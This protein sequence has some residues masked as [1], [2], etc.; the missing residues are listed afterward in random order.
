[1][2]SHFHTGGRAASSIGTTAIETI[3]SPAASNFRGDWDEQSLTASQAAAA[4]AS[5][6]TSTPYY[7]CMTMTEKQ[8]LLSTNSEA[9]KAYYSKLLMVVRAL[10]WV[11]FDLLG[12]DAFATEIAAAKPSGL[13]FVMPL[14]GERGEITLQL[15]AALRGD[16]HAVDCTKLRSDFCVSVNYRCLY[17]AQPAPHVGEKRT[18]VDI[19]GDESGAD[20]PPTESVVAANDM[21]STSAGGPEAIASDT[22]DSTME[23]EGQIGAA[24]A[25]SGSPLDSIGVATSE[26]ALAAVAAAKDR[27]KHGDVPP[28]Q[29]ASCPGRL[30]LLLPLSSRVPWAGGHHCSP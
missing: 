13:S 28:Q 4:A 1:M 27:A 12:K 25:A 10:D 20:E 2:Q 30:L 21:L 7:L 14:I 3:L 5:Q 22:P 26:E 24:A 6:I 9:L 17:H 15:I 8:R 23:Q 18:N 16:E 11:K 19:T 29:G